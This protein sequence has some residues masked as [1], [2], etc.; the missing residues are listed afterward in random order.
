MWFYLFFWGNFIVVYV[1][2]T[3]G[4]EVRERLFFYRN[5]NSIVVW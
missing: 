1:I 3:L 4:E 2:V 5:G